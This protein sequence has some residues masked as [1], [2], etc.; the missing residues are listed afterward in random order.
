MKSRFHEQP[1]ETFPAINVV[2]Y[3]AAAASLEDMTY[4]QAVRLAVDKEQAAYM[5]YQLLASSLQ[6]P[7]L[8]ALFLDL[9]QIE[10][11]HRD[12]LRREHTALRICEN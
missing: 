12:T 2:G 11:Q 8:N 4:T 6:E 9:A 1:L 10:A 3:A 5:L 7:A